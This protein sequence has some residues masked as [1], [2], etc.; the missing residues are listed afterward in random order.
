[1]GD[2]NVDI[3]IVEIIENE[4]EA[5]RTENAI[6]TTTNAKYKEL[7]DAYKKWVDDF[8][9]REKLE[10]PDGEDKYISLNAISMYF[11]L[12]QKKRN[13]N[14]GTA[15]TTVNAL[16]QLARIEGSPLY[17]LL[18]GECKKTI[19]EVLTSLEQKDLQ[20]KKD[21]PIDSHQLHPMRVI[22]QE[23]VAKVLDMKLNTGG[24]RWFDVAIVWAILSVTLLRWHNGKTLTLDKMFVY[25]DLPPGGVTT[26]HDCEEWKD[27]GNQDPVGWLFGFLIPPNQ[28]LKKNN[29]HQERKVEAVGAYRHKLVERDV[30]GLIAFMM[31]EVLNT[32]T[33]ISFLKDAPVGKKQWRDIKIFEL[34]YSATNKSFHKDMEKAGVPKWSK[35]T[36]MRKQGAVFLTSQGISPDEAKTMTKHKVDIFLKSYCAE[37]NTRVAY[38]LSGFNPLDKNETYFVPRASIGLPCDDTQF[39]L[40]VELLFPQIN[41]WKNELASNHGDKGYSMAANHFLDEVIPYMTQVLVQDGIYW[42]EK[43]PQNSAQH[44]L[45][46]RMTSAQGLNLCDGKNY[47]IWA[48]EKRRNAVKMLET[49]RQRSR[50]RDDFVQ[51]LVDRDVENRNETNKLQKEMSAMGNK[52]SAMATQ[53][54]AMLHN[55]QQLHNGIAAMP[56]PMLLAPRHPPAGTN[57]QQQAPIRIQL[58]PAANDVMPPL[59]APL[60]HP[61]AAPVVGMTTALSHLRNTSNPRKPTVWSI[62]K[63][64]TLTY[65]TEVGA[66]H[67]HK[68]IKKTMA[69]SDWNNCSKDAQNWS[70]LKLLNTRITDEKN[71]RHGIITD[72][73]AAEYLDKHERKEMTLN[74][75]VKF[76]KQD[77]TLGGRYVPP[78]K[79]RRTR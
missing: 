78:K 12:V 24:G 36:H 75:Y 27:M 79:R 17:P 61:P 19:K 4:T 31:F 48:G 44:L 41:V 6:K 11:I 10:L 23:E 69:A 53:M 45:V 65:L 71:S 38:V 70:M 26:P 33:S 74:E 20:K 51:G 22:T 62:N 49:H 46:S 29:M 77:N 40:L 76:L 72:L 60:P 66:I 57:L 73:E 68:N 9:P 42:L 5:M 64:Q 37:I 58:R 52:M 2:N 55:M 67:G 63:Y 30:T 39:P 28:Q 16:N 43:F 25:K 7:V 47:T 1:M 18:E 50:F 54:N 56:L 13:C 8:D 59:F 15:Q 34:G 21:R 14:K 3:D 35:V 32:T